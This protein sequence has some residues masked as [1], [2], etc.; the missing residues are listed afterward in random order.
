M[1]AINPLTT[2][3]GGI[4]SGIGIEEITGRCMENNPWQIALL[5]CCYIR[6]REAFHAV[7]VRMVDSFYLSHCRGSCV[8]LRR[9]GELF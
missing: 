1:N 6:Q 9:N 2:F 5:A 4:A 3:I 7:H 8:I